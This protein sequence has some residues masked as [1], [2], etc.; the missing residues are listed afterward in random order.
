MSTLTE[1]SLTAWILRAGV[2]C[3]GLCFAAAHHQ[4]QSVFRPVG[5]RFNQERHSTTV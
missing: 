2:F 5:A 1:L 4:R 3:L